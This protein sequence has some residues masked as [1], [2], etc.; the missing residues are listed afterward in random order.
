MTHCKNE[1]L[2]VITQSTPIE[3]RYIDH[4]ST[5]SNP[6]LYRTESPVDDDIAMFASSVL[7]TQLEI[8][9]MLLLRQ[10]QRLN[11]D[12]NSMQI[13]NSFSFKKKRAC[14][15]KF[16]LLILFSTAIFYSFRFFSVPLF[17][18]ISTHCRLMCHEHKPH[19][20]LWMLLINPAV[21]KS[22]NSLDT[23]LN[24]DDADLSIR[25]DQVTSTTQT[26]VIRTSSNGSMLVKENLENSHDVPLLLRDPISILLLIICNMPIN[27]DKSSFYCRF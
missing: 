10:T 13:S 6:Y 17:D 27:L 4:D 26:S 19:V 25:Q 12:N 18:V 2:T 7:R 9:L 16:F 5:I 14:F 1:A 20:K 15:G 21:W 24:I 3:F 11:T 22:L 23:K 8:D